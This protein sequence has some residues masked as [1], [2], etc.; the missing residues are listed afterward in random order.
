M[1]YVNYTGSD[2]VLSGN[3]GEITYAASAAYPIVVTV[4]G[5]NYNVRGI[6]DSRERT[7]KLSRILQA[8]PL[9]SI[10]PPTPN[11]VCSLIQPN[12]IQIAAAGSSAAPVSIKVIKGLIGSGQEISAAQMGNLLKKTASVAP[13]RRSTFPNAIEYISV[14]LPQ[15][16]NNVS[17]CIYVYVDGNNSGAGQTVRTEGFTLISR[18]VGRGEDSLTKGTI[19]TIKVDIESILDTFREDY[20]FTDITNLRISIQVIPSNHD[21]PNFI[22][23][24]IKSGSTRNTNFAFLNDLGGIDSIH[25]IGGKRTSHEFSTVIFTNNGKESATRMDEKQNKEASSGPITSREEAEYW[26]SFLRSTKKYIIREN[27][28]GVKEIV[29]IL[30]DDDTSVDIDSG[31]ISEIKFKYRTDTE[32]GADIRL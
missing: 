9:D 1:A 26:L 13:F 18:L 21:M 6:P 31:S 17:E 29:P 16:T 20:D 22:Y 12:I 19:I 14:Y 28:F 15:D 7:M 32:E 10:T 25:A 23:Y 4:G 3:A 11:D 2:I 24:K 27:I 30:I 8:L 5:N